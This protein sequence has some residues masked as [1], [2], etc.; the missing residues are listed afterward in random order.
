MGRGVSREDGTQLARVGIGGEMRTAEE[1]TRAIVRL[2]DAHEWL[3]QAEERRRA[4][5]EET[6]EAIRIV[7]EI[8][9]EA[10]AEEENGTHQED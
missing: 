7:Y 9:N 6:T 3:E 10:R 1:L 8:G 2:L 4:A 5:A